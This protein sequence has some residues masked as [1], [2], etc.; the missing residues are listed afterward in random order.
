MID[1]P[2]E[3]APDPASQPAFDAADDLA[4]D[5]L[6][7]GDL[8]DPALPWNQPPTDADLCGQCPDPSSASG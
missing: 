1:G 3:P 5:D 6:G 7:S 4:V 2:I 8:G